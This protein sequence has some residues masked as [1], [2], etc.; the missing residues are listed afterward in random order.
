MKIL[1]IVNS[2]FIISFDKTVGFKNGSGLNRN[3]NNNNNSSTS[4][5]NNRCLRPSKIV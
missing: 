4:N 3:N 5:N 2:C 1:K